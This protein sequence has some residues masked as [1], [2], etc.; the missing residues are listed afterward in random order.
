MILDP[1]TIH[2]TIN[3]NLIKDLNFRPETVKLPVGKHK[4]KFHDID[5]SSDF[6]AIT[7]KA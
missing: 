5:L 4:E 1:Y 6:R 2:I 7:S 3:T